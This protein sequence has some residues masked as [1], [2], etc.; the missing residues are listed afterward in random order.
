MHVELLLMAEELFELG[1]CALE[2]VGAVVDIVVVYFVEEKS[3]EK[4]PYYLQ[5]AVLVVLG[6]LEIDFGLGVRFL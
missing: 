2:I 3:F 1:P 6:S 5:S 4:A